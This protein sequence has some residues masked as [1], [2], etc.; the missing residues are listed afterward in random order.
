MEYFFDVCIGEIVG[1]I[2]YHMDRIE[3][4]GALPKAS[5]GIHLPLVL[6]NASIRISS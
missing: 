5:C 6:S 1:M 4:R 3:E 2:K